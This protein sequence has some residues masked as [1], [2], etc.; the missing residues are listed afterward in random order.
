MFEKNVG[1]LKK[2]RKILRILPAPLNQNEHKYQHR[3][4]QFLCLRRKIKRK[5]VS[6]ETGISSSNDQQDHSSRSD[7][8]DDHT[9][10]T[11]ADL[12]SNSDASFSL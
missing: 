6:N 8:N 12:T 4:D 10:S 11:S 1:K 3:S 5:Q 7:A 9:S 2:V